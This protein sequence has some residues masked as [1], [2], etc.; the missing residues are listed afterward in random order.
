MFSRRTDASK[1]ALAWLVV[2]LNQSGYRLFDT[3]FL[4]PHLASLGATEISRGEYRSRLAEALEQPADFTSHPL[5][6]S[7]QEVVQLNPQISKRK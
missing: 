1:I 3:Q 5:P 2:H 4:T 7:G 6:A